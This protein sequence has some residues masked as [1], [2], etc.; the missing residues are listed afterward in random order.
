MSIDA[1]VQEAG[2]AK[3]FKSGDFLIV[4]YENCNNCNHWIKDD[5]C[6][7]N[8]E[9]EAKQIVKIVDQVIS[10]QQSFDSSWPY[11]KLDD[12]LDIFIGS[13]S[14]NAKKKNLSSLEDFQKPTKKETI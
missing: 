12:V 10:L 4:E 8:V 2:C 7:Y 5:A 3:P 11:I 14:Q 6:W 13:K 1:L 9:T